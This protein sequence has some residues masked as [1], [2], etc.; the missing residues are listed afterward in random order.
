[1]LCNIFSQYDLCTAFLFFD[2]DDD[3]D[4]AAVIDVIAIKMFNGLF[5]LKVNAAVF[6]A[7]LH[8]AHN[9]LIY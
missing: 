4:D 8:R 6:V 2:D 9:Q 5:V 1:M 7:D 3:D